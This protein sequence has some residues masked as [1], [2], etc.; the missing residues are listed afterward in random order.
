MLRTQV[1]QEMGFDR[2]TEVQARCIPPLLTGRDV[3]GAA[4][5]GSGKTLAFLLP[6]VRASRRR[7]ICASRAAAAEAARARRCTASDATRPSRASA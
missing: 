1:L 4:R 5:T 7:L 6:V 2:M 3:L